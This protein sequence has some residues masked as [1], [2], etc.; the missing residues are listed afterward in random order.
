MRILGASILSVLTAVSAQAKPV[1][2]PQ[3]AERPPQFVLLAFD[4]SRNIRFWKESRAFARKTGVRFTYFISGVYFLANKDRKLYREPRRGP[5]RSAIGFGG[6][7]A[8]IG[9]RVEQVALAIAEGHEIASHANGHFNGSGYSKAQWTSE[10]GQFEDIMVKSWS[11]YSSHKEPKWWRKH[12]K[13][14]MK[15]HR[16]P[17]LGLGSGLFK[18]L[19]AKGY[20]YDTS[21][22]ARPGYWPK[23]IGGVWNFPLAYV[24]IAGT[25]RHTLSMDYNFY[26]ADSGARRGSKKRFGHFE[27]RMFKTYM[28]YFQHNYAGSGNR[29]PVDIGHHFSGWNGATYWRAMKRFAK[30]VCG[31]P[32]V[33]CG[34]YG[35]LQ[36]FLEENQHNLDTYRKGKFKKSP[37]RS[38]LYLAYAKPPKPPYTYTKPK[39]VLVAKAPSTPKPKPKKVRVASV[40]TTATSAPQPAV[41]VKRKSRKNRR[42]VYDAGILR[43]DLAAMTQAERTAYWTRVWYAKKGKT[44]PKAV[45]TAY[46]LAVKGQTEDT[47]VN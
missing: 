7:P 29:A 20:G 47:E 46:R 25:R 37:K 36:T 39:E 31:K 14:E 33:I 27:E 38:K 12:F 43:P 26:V 24:R 6:K 15:G 42:A 2:P 3:E 21:R 32:E 16:A 13:T 22:V 18:A 28:D 40:V 23:Q 11:R 44:P 30:A 1:V 19:K 34:T 41:V 9:E 17:L 45:V 35:E 10:L 8:D 5:G 4:G